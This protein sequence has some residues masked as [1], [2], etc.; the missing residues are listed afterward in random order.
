MS[1]Y[2]TDLTRPKKKSVRNAFIGKVREKNTSRTSV[3]VVSFEI[4]D[5]GKKDVP[6]LHQN[7]ENHKQRVS[8]LP[9]TPDIRKSGAPEIRGKVSWKRRV[10]FWSSEDSQEKEPLERGDFVRQMYAEGTLKY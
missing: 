5:A 6:Q 10:C 1:E 9:H 4:A 7:R 2:C 3:L 8:G